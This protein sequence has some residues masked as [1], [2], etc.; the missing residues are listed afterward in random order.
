VIL[1]DIEVMIKIRFKAILFDLDGTLLDTLKDLADSMNAVLGRHGMNTFPVDDYRFFVGKGLRELIRCVLPK[2]KISEQIVD[3][4]LSAMKIEYTKR[5]AENTKPY[6]G[7]PDLLDELQKISLPMAV[8]SNKSDEF[9]QIMVRTLLSKWQFQFIRGL[10]DDLPAKPD[11]TLALQI[12]YELKIQPCNFIYLG[13]TGIDMQT[14]NAAG[15]YA[16][17]A[18][19]GFRTAEELRANGAKTLVESPLQVLE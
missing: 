18:I 6:P 10:K 14:A 13:D 19:W 2:D 11:P 7:V 3:E 17:G 1:Y 8:L 5:W 16:A 15:M 12:A 4:F 9:T